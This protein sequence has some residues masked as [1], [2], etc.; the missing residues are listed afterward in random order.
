MNTKYQNISVTA[1][2][3]NMFLNYDDPD[4]LLENG[5]KF[6]K[7]FNEKM[8]NDLKDVVNFIVESNEI[9]Q[10]GTNVAKDYANITKYRM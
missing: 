10:D 3:A 2:L 9:T 5:I 6:P 4:F 7:S 1:N 8:R